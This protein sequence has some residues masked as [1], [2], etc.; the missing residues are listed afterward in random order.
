MD[1]IAFIVPAHNEAAF[2]PQTLAA[3]HEAA[4]AAGEPYEIVVVDDASTDATPAVAERCGVRVV[5]VSHR[6]ISATRKGGLRAPKTKYL[7]FVD[8]D[9]LVNVA[10]VAAALRALRQGAVAGGAPFY[11]EG[12]LPLWARLAEPLAHHYQ[13][14]ARLA[15]G[16]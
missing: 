15:A 3:L 7:F 9:T 6:Q 5:S 11:F 14:R 10:V 8:A 16:C 2:L 4:R 13:R 12:W 1:M